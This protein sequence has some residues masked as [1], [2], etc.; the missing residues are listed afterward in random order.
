MDP[1]LHLCQ[2]KSQCLASIKPLPKRSAELNAFCIHSHAINSTQLNIQQLQL[3]VHL[4]QFGHPEQNWPQFWLR[5]CLIH[6]SLVSKLE[7]MM[8]DVCAHISP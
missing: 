7:P 5:F 1:A 6:L 8:I 2:I 3:Q 4:A